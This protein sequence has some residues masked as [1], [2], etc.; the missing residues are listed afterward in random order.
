MRTPRLEFKNLPEATQLADGRARLCWGGG[1]I[2]FLRPHESP[3][4]FEVDFIPAEPSVV[5]E[6]VWSP[7]CS[8]GRG[9][10]K[11]SDHLGAICPSNRGAGLPGGDFSDSF[12][13]IL[14]HQGPL[15]ARYSHTCHSRK[16]KTALLSLLCSENHLTD[17]AGGRC[18][19]FGNEESFSSA[20]Q[21]RVWQQ[22]S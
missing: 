17:E 18:C 3:F 1:S 21:T 20:L 4:H 14:T 5:K 8:G 6:L 12:R 16:S 22:V 19:V 9:E 2:L 7:S 11:A 15:C 13:P 10:L